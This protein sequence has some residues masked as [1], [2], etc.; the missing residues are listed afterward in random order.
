VRDFRT[1]RKAAKVA[2][3]TALAAGALVGAVSAG[4]ALNRRRQFRSPGRGAG[5]ER[6]SA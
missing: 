1:G 4:V 2:V 5:P 6:R 3:P